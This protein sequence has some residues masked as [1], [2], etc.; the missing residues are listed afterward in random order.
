LEFKSSLRWN[1]RAN[2]T[3]RNIENAVLKT[4]AAFC[5]T[6][7]GELLIGIADNGEILGVDHDGFPNADKFLLHL[8]NLLMDRIGPEIVECVQYKMLT[9]EGKAVCH[10]ICKPSK[11][12]VWLNADANQWLFYVR[13]GPSSTELPG[14]KAVGYIRD[15]FDLKDRT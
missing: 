11:R 1:I 6:D 5:N 10:V 3:D 13:F 8:R 7:G 14:P 9:L 15:H 12:E 2:R 4:V